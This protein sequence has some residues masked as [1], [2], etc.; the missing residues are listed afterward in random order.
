[1][2]TPISYELDPEPVP[3][4]TYRCRGTAQVR[5]GHTHLC[6]RH[7]DHEGKHKCLCC[8]AW[9]PVGVDDEP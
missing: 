7:V 3:Y 4:P 2:N 5:P 9:N 1:M 6:R 8:F